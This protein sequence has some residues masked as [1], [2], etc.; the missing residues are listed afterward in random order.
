MADTGTG[1]RPSVRVARENEIM[2]VGEDRSERKREGESSAG[3]E[4]ADTGRNHRR[5]R[6][7]TKDCQRRQLNA[8]SQSRYNTHLVTRKGDGRLTD[9]T[10]TRLRPLH[11]PRP[12]P[13]SL[14]PRRN[15]SGHALPHQHRRARRRLKH[16]VHALRCPQHGVHA[17]TARTRTSILSAE[18]SLYARAPMALATRCAS[19]VVTNEPGGTFA[20]GEPT[21]THA[22]RIAVV[23]AQSV[24]R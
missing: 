19:A 1:R 20:P 4:P 10:T 22:V 12:A 14:V 7:G 15:V 16:V 23:R 8:L 13:P 6:A 9:H 18:H 17:R 11:V 21:R 3:G 24:Q 5:A 2:S